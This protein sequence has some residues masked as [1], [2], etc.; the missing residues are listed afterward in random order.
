VRFKRRPV[1]LFAVYSLSIGDFNHILARLLNVITQG[2]NC[3][4]KSFKRSFA[5]EKSKFWG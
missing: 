1:G 3:S 5:D 4:A 2:A